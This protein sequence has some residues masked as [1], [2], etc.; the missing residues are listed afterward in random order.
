MSP[1]SNSRAHST[2][3]SDSTVLPLRL[4]HQVTNQE[5]ETVHMNP[6]RVLPCL[7]AIFAASILVADVPPAAA[8][9]PPVVTIPNEQA[10]KGLD[11]ATQEISE[12]GDYVQLWQFNGGFNQEWY[13]E[14]TGPYGSYRIVNRADGKCLDGALQNIGLNGDFVQLWSCN[15]RS[16]QDWFIKQH[17]TGWDTIVN[18]ADG[19]CLDAEEQDIANNGDPVQLWA[20]NGGENQG[21]QVPLF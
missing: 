1:A 15:G 6:M 16:N 18:R 21:W 9:L 19:K 3:A 10:A 5:V 12:N 4:G 20:C 17:T 11:A 13:P 8:S 7:A 2:A 14:K